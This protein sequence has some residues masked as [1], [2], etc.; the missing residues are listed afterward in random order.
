MV[1]ISLSSS[2]MGSMCTAVEAVI[3]IKSGKPICKKVLD[4]V[5]V[6]DK[7]KIQTKNLTFQRNL[8]MN[9]ISFSYPESQNQIL[10]NVSINFENGKKYAIVGGSGT[11]SEL[12]NKNGEFKHLYELGSS[13]INS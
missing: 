1:V 5:A 9:E 7:K 6:N 2:I 13:M 8:K 10:K 4:T 11:F 12:I 3:E